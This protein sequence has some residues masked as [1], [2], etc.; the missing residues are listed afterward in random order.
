MARVFIQPVDMVQLINWTLDTWTDWRIDNCASTFI[1]RF[2]IVIKPITRCIFRC[3]QCFAWLRQCRALRLSLIDV[4]VCFTLNQLAHTT[5]S[6][7][8]MSFAYKRR[9]CECARSIGGQLCHRRGCSD[10]KNDDVSALNAQPVK[11][12]IARN[13]FPTSLVTFCA[14]TRRLVYRFWRCSAHIDVSSLS[15]NGTMKLA[16]NKIS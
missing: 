11:R 7:N 8:L 12:C 9:R 2:D 13:L 1:Q 3:C 5:R 14:L 10:E 4:I 6:L 15:G 16:Q